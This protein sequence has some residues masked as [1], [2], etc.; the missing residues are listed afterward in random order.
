MRNSSGKLVFTLLA[1][2]A[3]GLAAL[4]SVAPASAD[5]SSY[6]N[7]QASAAF[8]SDGAVRLG[9]STASPLAGDFRAIYSP[10]GSSEVSCSPVITRHQ[11]TDT[12]SYP[13]GCPGLN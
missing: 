6:R 2:A 5:V 11:K 10:S 9:M 8:A 1:S 3:L 7:G 4:A 13:A 12:F